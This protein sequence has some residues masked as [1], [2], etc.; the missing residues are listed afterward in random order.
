MMALMGSDKMIGLTQSFMYWNY[1]IF[2]LQ[3][4]NDRLEIGT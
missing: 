4:Q 1:Y 2:Y 3:I